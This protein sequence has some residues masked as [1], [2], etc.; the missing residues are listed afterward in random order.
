MH[1]DIIELGYNPIKKDE[2]IAEF[3]FYENFVG[4]I[5]DY[6]YAITEDGNRKKR[7]KYFIE[8]IKDIVTFD[9]KTKS[10]TFSENA[11]HLYFKSTYDEFMSIAAKLTLSDFADS[12]LKPYMLSKLIENKCGYY[13]YIDESYYTFD[14]FMRLVAEP[15]KPYYVGGVIGYHF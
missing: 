6:V 3:L 15:N 8:S 9:E 12:D 11:K 2:R 5:A 10:I 7:I 1:S 13:I 14:Y 4:T